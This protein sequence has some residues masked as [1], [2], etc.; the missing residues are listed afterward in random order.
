MNDEPVESHE[1]NVSI[2]WVGGKEGIITLEGRPPLPLSSPPQWDGKPDA[3]TPHDLFMSAVTGCYITTFATM[4]KRMKQ[5][6]EAHKVSGHGVVQKHPEGGFYF[7][8]IYITMEITVP[9]DASLS[10]V[11]RAVTLTEKY[12]QITR[13]IACKVHVEPKITQLD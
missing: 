13:S 9:K 4:M 5:P 11:E 1:F 10:K 12:C 6:L 7:T 3:Y 2:T 8:D